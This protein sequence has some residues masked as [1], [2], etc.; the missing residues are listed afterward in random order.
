M[1]KS[2]GYIYFLTVK[3]QIQSYALILRIASLIITLLSLLPLLLFFT[4][5]FFSLFLLL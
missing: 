1:K 5:F 2:V 4:V 3:I